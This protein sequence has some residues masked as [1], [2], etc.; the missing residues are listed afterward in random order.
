MGTQVGFTDG[1]CV[2]G[3][4]VGDIVGAGVGAG[5]GADV[6]ASV[7]GQVALQ[8][9]TLIRAGQG[10]APY[11]GAS[12]TNRSLD[13]FCVLQSQSV[14]MP[15]LLVMHAIGQGKLG[16]QLSTIFKDGQLSPPLNISLCKDLVR[17]CCPI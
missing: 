13:C 17:V 15:Q 4:G 3:D 2:D 10:S 8:S 9:R 11:N 6:G 16:T 14:H 12:K 5:V 7:G 1:G